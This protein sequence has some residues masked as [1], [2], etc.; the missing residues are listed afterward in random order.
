ME[1]SEIAV[2]AVLLPIKHP[3]RPQLNAILAYKVNS[4]N[5]KFSTYYRVEELDSQFLFPVSST[6]RTESGSSL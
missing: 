3:V 4:K 1:L 6:G 2:G 5:I